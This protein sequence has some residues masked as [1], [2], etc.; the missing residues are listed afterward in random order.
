MITIR[1]ANDRGKG[2]YGWLKTA[3]TFSFANYDDPDFMGFHDL[4]VINE[5]VIA[6]SREFDTHDHSDMEIVT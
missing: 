2:G 5:D 6:P 1:R 4:R 3:Y